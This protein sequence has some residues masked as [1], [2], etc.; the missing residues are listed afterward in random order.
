MLGSR[1]GGRLALGCRLANAVDD[2]IDIV[3][4]PPIEPQCCAAGI[5]NSIVYVRRA[6]QARVLLDMALPIES[7]LGKSARN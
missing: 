6:Q 4:V 1:L 5:C 2:R 7:K 3:R